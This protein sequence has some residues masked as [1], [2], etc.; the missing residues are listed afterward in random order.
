MGPDGPGG[1]CDLSSCHAVGDC[2]CLRHEAVAGPGSDL[3]VGSTGCSSM[4]CSGTR[5]EAVVGHAMAGTNPVVLARDIVV[6]R[7]D[8]S[9]QEVVEASQ[10]V[11][12]EDPYHP[13]PVGMAAVGD[14][15]QET[16]RDGSREGL[17]GAHCCIHL[18]CC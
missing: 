12:E 13:K 8:P 9:A 15:Y 18:D 6:R 16:A 14:H 3:P 17:Q 2:G 11:V 5:S 1:G 7:W 4:S 10:A